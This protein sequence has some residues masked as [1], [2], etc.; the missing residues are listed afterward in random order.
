MGE[1]AKVTKISALSDLK[2][3]LAKICEDVEEAL[4]STEME[5]RRV[6]G[7][8]EHDQ[9]NYWRRAV[10]QFEQKLAQ[11]RNELNRRKL[12]RSSG[13]RIDYTEQKEAVELLQRKLEEAQEKVEATRR[14]ARTV[15]RAVD[16]YL[17][18]ARR[19]AGLVEGDPPASVAL[20]ERIV[21][22]LDAYLLLSST[23]VRVE[24]T[25]T[26]SEV[27]E[28]ES[29]GAGVAQEGTSPPGMEPALAPLTPDPS[30][31]KGRGGILE[32]GP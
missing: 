22:A 15:Q 20:L 4:C 17:T 16:E 23:A 32:G 28:S 3:L 7:W 30:G 6:V 29:I 21:S 9:L 10:K 13:Q 1:S 8:L 12:M 25:P 27:S 24:E 2:G 11:A 19:L 26:S 18:Q 5:A 31:P 14:W